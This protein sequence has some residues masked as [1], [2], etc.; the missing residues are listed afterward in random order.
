MKLFSLGAD[1]PLTKLFTKNEDGTIEKT[2]YPLTK[3]LTSYEETISTTE[4]FYQAILHAAESRRCLLKGVLDRPLVNESRAGRTDPSTPTYWVV[5][6][7]DGLEGI[8]STEQFISDVLPAEFGNVSYVIQHSASAGMGQPGMR[9]HIFFLLEEAVSPTVLKNWVTELNLTNPLLSESLRLSKNAMTLCFSLDRTVC[10]ND[11][12]IYIAPPTFVGMDDPLEGKRI[13]L[14]TKQLDK[15]R[16]RAPYVNAG[17]QQQRINDKV[18]E[19]RR[20]LGLRK[21]QPRMVFS[22]AI[23]DW[24]LTNPGQAQVTGVKLQNGFVRLNING[25]DSW[26]YYFNPEN[27]RYLYNFKGEPIVVLRDFVPEFWSQYRRTMQSDKKQRVIVFRYPAMDCWWGMTYDPVNDRIEGAHTIGSRDKLEDFC[28]NNDADLPDP[29]PDWNYEFQP[30]NE[31]ICDEKERFANRWQPTELLR[32]SSPCDEMPP[33]SHK[34][35]WSVVGNDKQSYDHLVNW[36]AFIIQRREKT[37]TAWVLHGTQ[38]TGKGL[39]VNSMLRPILGYDHCVTKELHDLDDKFNSYL[40]TSI[41]VNIDEAKVGQRDSSKV[42]NQLKHAITE[43]YLNIRRM[44]R[45]AAQVRNYSNFIFTSNDY[46]SMRI[47][48]ADRRFNVAPRQETKL[49]ISNE[50]IA[51]LELELEQFCGYLKGYEVDVDKVRTP[52]NNAAKALVRKH[53]LDAI[54]QFCEA[55][56]T[57]DYKFFLDLTDYGAGLS[58]DDMEAWHQC[59]QAIKR[60][61]QYVNSEMPCVVKRKELLAVY[62]YAF[63]NRIKPQKFNRLLAHKNVPEPEQHWSDNRNQYGVRVNWHCDPGYFKE[64]EHIDTSQMSTNVVPITRAA[65]HNN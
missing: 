39:L 38:G 46:D 17:A 34:V 44:H 16:F 37:G 51:Q 4:D 8:A 40:E 50:E 62:R 53:G 11:K 30:N 56:V 42:V 65:A 12:L 58:T 25:G 21:V 48:P 10:Q 20:V 26:G 24:V 7:I 49:D 60:W 1:E 35:L 5:F 63:D 6:D 31:V 14:V 27:P 13:E 22:D 3:N 18:T 47:D 45:E 15:V 2:S 23:S 28:R 41:V 33:I 43:P 32:S 64:R 59:E 57:G 55:L 36:L 9:A 19:L 29:I 52:M 54:E 61:G